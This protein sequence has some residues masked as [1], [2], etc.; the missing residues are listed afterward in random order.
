VGEVPSIQ[1]ERPRL[2][3]KR[4]QLGESVK[5]R[6]ELRSTSKK[7]QELLVDLVVHFVKSNG[8]TRPKVFKIKRLTLPPGASVEFES[9]VSFA[10]MTTRR[11]Y[12]GAHKLEV[13]INGRSFEFA[14]LQV[15]P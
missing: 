5:I 8:Q 11:H 15:L 10:T 9:Q 7:E 6:F 1:V 2:S 14:Q 12:P 13:L 4:I 3:A